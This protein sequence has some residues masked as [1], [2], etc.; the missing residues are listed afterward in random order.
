MLAYDYVHMDGSCGK[1]AL[2]K[3]CEAN[4]FFFVKVNKGA[5][6]IIVGRRS[7]VRVSMGRRL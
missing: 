4:P 1:G 5:I 3:F 6:E 7:D 2:G